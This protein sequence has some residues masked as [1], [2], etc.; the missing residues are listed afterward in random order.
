[1]WTPSKCLLLRI[2]KITENSLLLCLSHISDMAV[3]S[4][5]AKWYCKPTTVLSVQRKAIWIINFKNRY[6]PVEPLFKRNKNYDTK[7]N[8]KIRKLSFGFWHYITWTNVCP[9]LSLIM[10]VL[11]SVYHCFKTDYLKPTLEPINLGTN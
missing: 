11:S 8:N 3:K 4:Y 10:K 9:F 1:M 7:Q 6:T 5:L 2:T